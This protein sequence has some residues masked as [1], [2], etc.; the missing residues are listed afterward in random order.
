MGVG[1]GLGGQWALLGGKQGGPKAP[2]DT[3]MPSDYSQKWFGGY[4]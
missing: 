4:L 3:Q 1:A 2:S